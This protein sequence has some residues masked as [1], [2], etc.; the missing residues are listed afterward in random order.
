MYALAN[1][2]C[3][4]ADSKTNARVLLHLRMYLSN[5]TSGF[6]VG[7]IYKAVRGLLLFTHREAVRK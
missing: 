7:S 4:L 2:S 6:R 3:R 1:G 5:A